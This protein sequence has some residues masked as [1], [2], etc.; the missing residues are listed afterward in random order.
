[1][2]RYDGIF[3]LNFL[4]NKE[5][6]EFAAAMIIATRRGDVLDEFLGQEIC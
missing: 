6:G 1:M 3:L 4:S 5:K 2:R